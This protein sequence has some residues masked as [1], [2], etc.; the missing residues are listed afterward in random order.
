M[1]L[2][3]ITSRLSVETIDGQPQIRVKDLQGNLSALSLDELKNEFRSN[4]A[5]KPLIAAS[6]ASGGGANGGQG[7]GATKKPSELTTAERSEWQQRDPV[8]FK[9]A[10]DAGEFN[11]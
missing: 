4:A 11:K 5:F 3:H 2:P 1:L 9:R 10:L 7:G 8:A 6:N